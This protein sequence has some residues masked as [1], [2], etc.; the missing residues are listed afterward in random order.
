[1]I[2]NL[3]LAAVVKMFLNAIIASSMPFDLVILPTK[4]KVGSFSFSTFLI[5]LE[6]LSP[7]A[8]QLY[9]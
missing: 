1:M 8:I 3:A 5:F 9:F 2:H 7:L 4:I 6:L